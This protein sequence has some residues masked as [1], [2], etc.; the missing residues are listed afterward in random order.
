MPYRDYWE[1][2]TVSRLQE[3]RYGP[4]FKKGIDM[5]VSILPWMGLAVP[6]GLGGGVLGRRARDNL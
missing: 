4:L 6:C 5:K 2:S 1:V 3:T